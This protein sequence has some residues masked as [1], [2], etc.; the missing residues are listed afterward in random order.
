MVFLSFGNLYR[1]GAHAAGFESAV[2]SGAEVDF[3]EKLQMP[4]GTAVNPVK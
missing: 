1:P 3:V 4:E 2:R